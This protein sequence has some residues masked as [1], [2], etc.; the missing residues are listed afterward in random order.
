MVICDI[1]KTEKSGVTCWMISENHWSINHRNS[2][3]IENHN[4]CISCPCFQLCTNIVRLLPVAVVRSSQEVLF[5]H[6]NFVCKFFKYIRYK[7][8]DL[9]I[10]IVNHVFEKWSVNF[11]FFPRLVQLV[12]KMIHCHIF[13]KLL[14][15]VELKISS[16]LKTC[17]V[18]L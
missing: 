11:F 10:L 4:T 8:P 3:A 13:K 17:L 12:K 15:V 14:T 7:H 18:K 1:V 16:D 6:P 2:C 5:C 9:T